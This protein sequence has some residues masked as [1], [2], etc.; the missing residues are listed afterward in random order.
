MIGGDPERSRMHFE[1][2][3]ELSNRS[4]LMVQTFYAATYGRMAF[5]KE[6][7][8]SLLEEVLSFPIDQVPGNRLSNQIAKSR[9]KELLEENFFGD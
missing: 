4:F 1:R 5:D 7:H 3:L 2:A 6:L 9:A 8:D